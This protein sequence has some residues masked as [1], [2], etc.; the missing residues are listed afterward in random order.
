MTTV[1]HPRRGSRNRPRPTPPAPSRGLARTRPG[2]RE[3]RPV[4]RAPGSSSERPQFCSRGFSDILGKQLVAA[5]VCGSHAAETTAT[6]RGVPPSTI[7]IGSAVAP[8]GWPGRRASR[9]REEKSGTVHGIISRRSSAIARRL[10]GLGRLPRGEIRPAHRN[11]RREQAFALRS[12]RGIRGLR[13]GRNLESTLP[14]A[15]RIGGAERPLRPPS[16]PSASRRLPA[17]L[18][19]PL[20]VSRQW[21]RHV[22]GSAR[23]VA[24]PGLVSG[25]QP[26]LL[27]KGPGNV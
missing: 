20:S 6:A 25:S 24:S 10:A 19:R 15:R 16:G 22:R 3:S 27:R 7:R 26:L 9:S 23:A 2:R 4:A 14:G 17:F 21:A 12:R 13:G 1:S 11:R 18:D 8:C 5:R